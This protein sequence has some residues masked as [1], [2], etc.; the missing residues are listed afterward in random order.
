MGIV[1]W[2]IPL[3]FAEMIQERFRLAYFVETGTYRGGTSSWA[4]KHF[5]RVW[6]IEAFEPL[7]QK[8]I[9]RFSDVKNV[10]V[11]FGSS[12]H[13]LNSIVRELPGPAM[14]WLDGP[15]RPRY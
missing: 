11:I 5:D 3:P 14:F 12:A 4:S 2:G 1:H 10:T 13:E 7:Y 6:T 9:E 15:F 8:A